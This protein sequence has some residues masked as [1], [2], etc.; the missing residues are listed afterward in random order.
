MK[1]IVLMTW[2]QLLKLLDFL[3]EVMKWVMP[4]VMNLTKNGKEEKNESDKDAEGSE[5]Q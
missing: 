1:K 5:E 2:E 3:F 4:V